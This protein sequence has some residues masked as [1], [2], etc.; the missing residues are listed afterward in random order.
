MH[1]SGKIRYINLYAILGG[2]LMPHA[3]ALTPEIYHVGDL[4]TVNGLDCH[5]YLLVDG[6]E[7]VLIDP[8]SVLDIEL[9]LNKVK[10]IIPLSQVKYIVLDHEDP[11]FCG[12]V[13][14]LEQQGLVASIITSW[15]TMTIIQYYNIK[16]PYYLIEEHQ[17]H[18]TLKSGRVL[19]FIPTPYLHF[20]GSFVTY[21]SQSNTLFSGDLFGAFTYNRTLYADEHYEGKMM[22]FHEHYMPSNAILRPVMTTIE[23]YKIDRILPQHGSLIMEDPYKYIRILKELECGTLINPVKQ[24]LI[25]SGGYLRILNDLLCYMYSIF[26]PEEVFPLFES[27][28]GLVW[29]EEKAILDYRDDGAFL[30]QLLF[31]SILEE[32]GLL[33]L[34]ILEPFVKNTTNTY[35]IEPPSTYSAWFETATLTNQKLLEKNEALEITIKNVQDRHFR[36]PL[37]GMFN[38]NFFRS[39]LMEELELE[40]WRDMGS[41]LLISIDDF[42]K[43]KSQFGESEVEHTLSNM[44]YLIKSFF[45]ETVVFRMRVS[46]FAVYLKDFGHL[47]VVDLAEQLRVLIGNSTLFI[48]PMTISLGIAFQ[49][50]IRLDAPTPE[51]TAESYIETCLYRLQLAKASGKN[52]VVYEGAPAPKVDE[53]YKVLLVDSDSTH[54]EVLQTFLREMEVDVLSALDGEEAYRLANSHLP[55]LIISDVILPKIDGFLLRE[56]LLQRSETKVIPFIY[57]SHQKDDASVRRAIA[58]EVV[59]Y[60]KKPYLLSELLG[61]TQILKKGLIK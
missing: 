51:I 41:L 12:G 34:S 24:N 40:E 10:E 11:D 20:A 39:F 29:S 36:C 8:G 33:W 58:L 61:I 13:P 52:H 55:N 32:K 28:P 25:A 30:W 6:D 53:T 44:A 19:E 42:Y 48:R 59:H 3:L 47:E 49:S 22:A 37:T 57:C 38:E 1:I 21:D 9:V 50:E 60:L 26:K 14:Y 46:E 43:I 5:P 45:G 18:L 2:L 17:N 31:E 7:A 4:H 16:S 27:L 56:R 15:R 23:K 54:L 35:G